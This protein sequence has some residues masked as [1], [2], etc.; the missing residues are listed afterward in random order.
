MSGSAAHASHTVSGYRETVLF[1]VS[2]ALAITGDHESANPRRACAVPLD[3]A[4]IIVALGLSALTYRFVEQ[5]IRQRKPWP[6]AVSGQAIM[7]GFLILASVAAL[8]GHR[9]ITYS[10]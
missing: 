7:T 6:F 1:L 8:S 10:P 4:L 2:M 5:P 9:P 3:F